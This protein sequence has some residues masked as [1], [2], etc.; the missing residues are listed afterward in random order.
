MEPGRGLLLPW[1]PP[2]SLV[3]MKR[4]VSEGRLVSQ[5]CEGVGQAVGP[6]QDVGDGGGGSSS[7]GLER[8]GTRKCLTKFFLLF[9]PR[10]PERDCVCVCLV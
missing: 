9:S 7:S 3:P 4:E 8:K 6:L 1:S 2:K 5:V 10:S